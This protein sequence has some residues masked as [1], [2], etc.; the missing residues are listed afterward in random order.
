MYVNTRSVLYIF[1]DQCIINESKI[2]L[3]PSRYNIRY[4]IL[5]FNKNPFLLKIKMYMYG[6]YPKFIE[7][8]NKNDFFKF[9]DNMFDQNKKLKKIYYIDYDIYNIMNINKNKIL[10]NTKLQAISISQ[11]MKGNFNYF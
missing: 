3:D 6:V 5:T 10:D 1:N 8:I 2:V 4:A 9:I 11:F 7:K